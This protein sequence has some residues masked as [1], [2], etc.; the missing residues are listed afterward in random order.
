MKLIVQLKLQPDEKSA[1]ALRETLERANAAANAISR[2]AWEAQ[3]FR[4]YALHKLVYHPIRVEF[5]LSAQ[6]VVR[7]LAKVADSYKLDRN[8][9]RVFRPYGSIAFDDRILR[10]LDSSVSIWTVKGRLQIPFVCGERQRALLAFRQGETDLVYRDG[11]F[12]VLA[13]VNYE[14][15]PEGEVKDVLGIDLGI[16]NLATDSD[17][18]VHS[19]AHVNSLRHRHRRLRAKTARKFTRSARRL[20][21]KRSEKER[22]FA[23]HVNHTIS[24]RIVVEAQRTKR[25]IAIEELTGIRTRVRARKPQR[26]TLSSWSF[27]QLRAFIEYKARRVG[28]PVVAVD[29]RNSSRTCPGCGY[30]DK[31]NR[32]SQ[33]LF[34]CRSCGLAGLADYFAAVI[35]ADR[36][37]AAVSQ[38]RAN[39]VGLANA[40][41]L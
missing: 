8:V 7:L 4:Q 29:P 34:S 15:P 33:S 3:T 22:R 39:V 36:G 1:K 23:T 13:T 19:G 10:Y 6:V 17:G 38:P 27:A 37:R 41:V 14:E 30:S 24:K 21:H 12:Y 11:S 2:R 26:A 31:A 28:V 9:L 40:Q 5:D 35:L 18:N 16:V 25:A 20:F 32:P